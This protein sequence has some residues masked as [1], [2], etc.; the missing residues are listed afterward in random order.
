MPSAEE[1]YETHLGPVYSWMV[2]DIEAALARSA[3]ELEALHLPPRSGGTAL[4]LGAGIGLHALPLAQR[5]YAVTAIDSCQALLDELTMRAQ[6]LPIKTIRA[7]IAT[8]GSRITEP[9][10][11]ILCMGDTLTH[12]PE[13]PPSKRSSRKHLQHWRREE[14]L[15]QRF[16]TTSHPRSRRSG[17]SSWFAATRGA[18]SPA[19]SSTA[20]STCGSTIFCTSAKAERWQQ[21]V[22]SYPK[23]RLDP[24]WVVAKLA[25][26]GFEVRRDPGPAAMVRIVATKT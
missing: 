1:H 26:L 17:A 7:D 9:L 11:V 2:G 8:F 4:D 18:S 25:A 23:L 15:P 5:G 12:L 6:D 21:R 16:A 10:D 22:S 3:V 14:C 24:Q 20:Q 19:F 13:L